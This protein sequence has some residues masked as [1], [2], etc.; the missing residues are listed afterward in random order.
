[1]DRGYITI[2]NPSLF[3]DWDRL[4]LMAVSNQGPLFDE[5]DRSKYAIH[6][7]MW[8]TKHEDYSYYN[9]TTA[10]IKLW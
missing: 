3:P 1:M 4:G 8:A 7:L 2:I 10:D 5:Y 6:A 9:L